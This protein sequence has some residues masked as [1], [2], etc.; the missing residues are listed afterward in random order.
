MALVNINK[1]EDIPWN[2][3]NSGVLPWF[4]LT[5]EYPIHSFERSDGALLVLNREFKNVLRYILNQFF[6]FPV[7]H[8]KETSKKKTVLPVNHPSLLHST[9]RLL[10]YLDYTVLLSDGSIT[11]D[12]KIKNG[13]HR[14][15]ISVF[16]NLN[17][18]DN[19][20]IQA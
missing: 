14:D 3:T 6:G 1:R 9:Q 10:Y 11:E 20:P 8:L 7:F 13:G 2:K 16:W 17:P 4:D 12:N 15:S 18:F 19:L 5:S